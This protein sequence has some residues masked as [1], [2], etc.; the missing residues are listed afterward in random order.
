MTNDPSGARPSDRDLR[1]AL[2]EAV[3]KP[4][5][6]VAWDRLYGGIMA[7]AESHFHGPDRPVYDRVAAW[8]SRGIPL[9][10]AGLAAAILALW[11][12]PVA[13]PARDSVPPGLQ[14]VAEELLAGLPEETLQLLGASVDVDGMLT[15]LATYGEEER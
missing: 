2:Q 7:H 3:P 8:S 5:E 6:E 15:A 1:N 13:P 12:L 11:M 4:Y 9:A 10:G 14:P